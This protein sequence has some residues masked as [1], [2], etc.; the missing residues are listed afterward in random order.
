MTRSEFIQ[1]WL[2]KAI[3]NPII[4]RDKNYCQHR[5]FRFETIRAFDGKIIDTHIKLWL[6]SMPDDVH[7]IDYTIRQKVYDKM[8]DLYEEKESFISTLEDNDKLKDDFVI[9]PKHYTISK[10]RG[11]TDLFIHTLNKHLRDFAE[12]KIL[13]VEHTIPT[14]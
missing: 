11:N 14:I 1:N 8:D 13:A 6:R 2:N 10:R 12:C 5:D 4:G 3:A 9:H 7:R